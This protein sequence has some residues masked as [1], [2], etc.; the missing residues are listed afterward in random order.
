[1]IAARE[2]VSVSMSVSDEPSI[3]KL[4]QRSSALSYNPY[5]GKSYVMP[6]REI[7]A[8]HD[9]FKINKKIIGLIWRALLGLFFNKSGGPDP[10]DP[11]DDPTRRGRQSSH[12]EYNLD[13]KKDPGLY[14]HWSGL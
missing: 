4:Y 8:I 12:Y 9:E 3:G 10:D 2:G 6:P 1:M 14:D 11:I 13:P 5:T 7:P